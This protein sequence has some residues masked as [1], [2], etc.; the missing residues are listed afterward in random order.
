MKIK[1][2]YDKEDI[3]RLIHRDLIANGL[4]H[5]MANAMYKGS[6]SVSLEVEGT[7]SI[8]E[9][10]RVERGETARAREQVEVEVESQETSSASEESVGDMGAIL[11][12]SRRNASDKKPMY[13]AGHSLM[14]GESV[15]WPGNPQQRNR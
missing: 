2:T 14:E 12:Q 15:E 8:E 11:A 6:A 9:E 10:P 4:K 5:D 13:P 3:L 1:V 7:P